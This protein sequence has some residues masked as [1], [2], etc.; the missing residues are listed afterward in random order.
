MHIPVLLKEVIENLDPKSGSKFIDAT[1]NGGGHAM[2]LLERIKPDGNLLGIEWDRQI[3]MNLESRIKNHEI[4]SGL[5]IVNDSYINLK[6]I[7]ESTDFTGVDG[8][9]FDLGLSTWQLTDGERGFTFLKDEKLDMRFN[10]VSGNETAADILNNYSEEDIANIIYNFGEERYSRSIA[11]EIIK[12]RKEYPI[13]TTFQLIEII[14]KSVPFRYRMPAG[15]QRLHYATRTFQALRIAVNH[16]LENIE[17]GLKE[18]IEIVKS[19]GRIAVISFHSL[20]DRIVKNLF[21]D[22][23]KAGIL[24]IITKKPLVASFEERRANPNSRSAKLRVAQKK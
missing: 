8:V 19:E 9:L 2:A 1:I 16:E 4:P 12:D 5:T 11:R 6:K 3:Y 20:E 22:Q 24:Q 18:A 13:E 17:T 21:R 23:A 10:S 15:R 14:K 7:A